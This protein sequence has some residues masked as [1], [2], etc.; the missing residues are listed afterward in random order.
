MLN[1]HSLTDLKITMKAD[2][3]NGENGLSTTITNC[4]F[5]LLQMIFCLE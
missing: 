1:D 2:A 3:G 4:D 5:V